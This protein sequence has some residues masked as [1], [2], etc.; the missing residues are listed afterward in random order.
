[1]A[2]SKFVTLAGP[3][4]AVALFATSSAAV[5]KD[6]ECKAYYGPFL[7]NTGAPCTS[8]IGL[9]THGMLEGEFPAT[10]DATFLTMVPAGDDSDPSKYVYRGV[11]V[12]TPLDGSGVIYTEDTGVIHMPAPGSN[13]PAPF[14][15]KAIVSSGSSAYK[16]TTGGF[17]AS[18]ELLFSTGAAEGSFSAVLCGK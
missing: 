14:V 7:S 4:T 18:G 3:L 9:C 10:Y 2:Q 15:T 17:I 5:A 11:S 16:K 13:S 12:V 6:K 8:P 1:M